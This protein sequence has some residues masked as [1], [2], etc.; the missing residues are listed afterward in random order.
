MDATQNEITARPPAIVDDRP[1]QL[2]W[3]PAE[4]P[5]A[6]WD[7]P[8]ASAY[9]VDVRRGLV[10]LFRGGA[11]AYAPVNGGEGPILAGSG[12][13]PVHGYAAPCPPELLGDATFRQDH[14]LRYAYCTGA[15]ANG[16]ACEA[17]V[18]AMG[19][20]GMLS[21]F[22]AAGLS[23][24]RIG[25][26]IDTLQSRLG[27]A[28]HGFNLIHSPNEPKHE[29]A[30]V[31]L[32]LAKGVRLVEAAAY[33]GLTPPL[34][35]YRVTGLYRDAS[36][37]V[38][39]PNRV[40][41]KVSREEVAAKFF[42]PA[43]E[44]MLEELVAEGA[45]T[46]QEAELA[47]EIPVAQDL[48]AEADSGGHTDN[49]P[50]VTLLPTLLALRDAK[51][52]EHGYAAPL[53]V[54][55][56]G[57]IGTPEAAAAAFAMGAA[58]VLTGSVNQACVESGTSDIVRQM[59]AETRQADVCMAPAADM[60]EMGVTV[61]VL[62]RGTMFAM[63][64][65]KLFAHYRQYA[66]WKAIPAPERMKLEKTVFRATF[67]EIWRETE[68]FFRQSAPEEL[69]RAAAD[70][71]HK[72]A[73]VFRWYLGKASSWANEG[74]ASR[75]IDYQIWCGP[76]MGAFNE[77]VRGSVL[78]DPAQRSV[79]TV[80]LNLLRGAAVL[81]RCAGLRA[82]GFPVP[83]AAARIVPLSLDRVKELLS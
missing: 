11:P 27:N 75:K 72:M 35:K 82:Q 29:A 15:M 7:T 21:F 47:R 31:D 23:L 62:K 10:C 78:E 40:V 66:S 54:G 79:V 34:V 81:T 64:G 61:Q 38:I 25:R 26:A 41:A 44:A 4:A 70:E 13:D 30:T 77:G 51:Q 53:R 43:P 28:P 49:R 63:R 1:P 59:L 6:H 45:I 18:E 19:K 24:E 57:G 8:N 65:D 46:P 48:T 67:E 56:A 52:A 83:E 60:F 36:G 16:I 17:V 12:A 5:A 76:A 33:L 71:K 55:L 22:G 42:S 14:G 9:I 2:G 58:Y 39:A 74:E 37:R 80:A 73:L 50:A 20:A 3:W 32:Y 68:A 69:S